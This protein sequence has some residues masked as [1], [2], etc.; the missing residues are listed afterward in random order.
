MARLFLDISP[1]RRYPQF[2]RLWIGYV[3]SLLGSQLTVVAVAYQIYRITGSSL[4]V[5]LVSLAQLGPAIIG[6]LIGGSIADA[7]DRRKL[8]IIANLLTATCSACLAVNSE[9]SHPA[10][11]P[12]FFFAGIAAGFSGVDN[13][14]RTA[15]MVQ[16]VD[17]QSLT[18]ANALRTLSQQIAYVV[19]PAIAG[20]LLAKFGVSAVYWVDVATFGAAIVA[21]ISL[22]PVIPEG[23]GTKFGLRS[24]REG[25]GYLKGRQAIQGCFIADLDAMVLG[26]PN[27]LFPAMG[28]AYFHGTA[29]TV[30]YLYAAPGVGA[31][32]AATLSGWT[33]RIRRPGY[34]VIVAIVI[35][36]AAIAG[37]GLVPWLP[38]ALALLAIAGGADVI[39][40]VF[41]S[42]II[43]FEVPD[44]LRGRLTSMQTAVVQG[45]PRVGN[46]EAGI[47]AQLS[48]TQISVVS[49]GIACLVGIA[50]MARFMPRFARYEPGYGEIHNH[51]G[52]LEDEAEVTEV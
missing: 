33:S 31:F 11:W 42:T 36:G 35:W 25:F 8:L 30:G 17:R 26:M 37:F 39:S 16:L 52:G 48:N 23:G 9:L 19:G 45:G 49:G 1:L 18:S 22:R 15:T 43:Q 27:A 47:V 7:M 21:V 24:I 46:T 12:L 41:R 4:D 32:L 28:L 13:P 44:R 29:Q 3:I 40:A 50:L 38:A 51:P 14:T 5:G 2:R 10:L 20:L 6:P 34:A